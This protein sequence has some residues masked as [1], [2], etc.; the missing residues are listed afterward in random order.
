[1]IPRAFFFAW[2]GF[3]VVVETPR[4]HK[5]SRASTHWDP[6]PVPWA[7]GACAGYPNVALSDFGASAT[8]HSV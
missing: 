7:A 2:H 5:L 4:S 6:E 3:E 8:G 1:M